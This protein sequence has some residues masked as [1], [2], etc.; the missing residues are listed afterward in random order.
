MMHHFTSFALHSLNIKS[1]TIV[2][3]ITTILYIT[4]DKYS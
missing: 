3:I 4:S 1:K 2:L